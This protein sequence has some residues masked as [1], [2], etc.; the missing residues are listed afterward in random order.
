M[1]LLG[2]LSLL[3]GLLPF[4]ANAE[5]F[6]YQGPCRISYDVQR[7]PEIV[8]PARS[9]SFIVVDYQ[10]GLW[11]RFHFYREAGKKK[12]FSNGSENS[13]R[14]G[15]AV[16]P[17]G[18]TVTVFTAATAV[19][20]PSTAANSQ[21]TLQGI[22]T[23]VTTRTEPGLVTVTRPRA[24]TM[25]IRDNTVVLGTVNFS[26]RDYTLSLHPARTI[27]ANN[28][29]LTPADVMAALVTEFEAKGYTLDEE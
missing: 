1:K 16:L 22:N 3:A 23:T 2:F 25:R 14:G 28:A 27:K 4:A 19:S 11:R 15:N 13:F 20:D 5:V 17:S 24:V 18:K 26:Q 10:N 29:N 8:P 7:D 12:Y 21:A 9:S 6:I